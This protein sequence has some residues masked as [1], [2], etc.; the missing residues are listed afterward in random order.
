GD[1][2]SNALAGIGGALAGGLAGSAI[3]GGISSGT[4]IEFIVREDQGGDIAV[5]QTNED[6]L[7]V[8]DRVFLSRGDRVRIARAAGQPV[9]PGFQ[10]QMAP[11]GTVQGAPI[12]H[13]PGPVK[14]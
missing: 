14:R 11:Q 6:A 9:Q 7:Q 2:R 4:A 12:G 8:G 1:W 10:P 5:V 13:S 3:E